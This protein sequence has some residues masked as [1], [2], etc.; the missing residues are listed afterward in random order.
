MKKDFKN[1]K[2]TSVLP[3]ASTEAK[4][5]TLPMMSVGLDVTLRWATFYFNSNKIMQIIEEL[6]LFYDFETVTSNKLKKVNY[7]MHINRGSTN[8]NKSNSYLLKNARILDIYIKYI[9]VSGVF[10]IIAPA[11]ASVALYIKNEDWIFYYPTELWINSANYYIPIYI[12]QAFAI[13]NFMFLI[14]AAE[15]TLLMIMAHI[16][17]QFMQIAEELEGIK[18]YNKKIK[19]LIN[20]HCRISE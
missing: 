9:C 7:K 6:K 8:V 1:K 4:L 13:L 14:V 19:V 16:I 2:F 11:L 5:K 18:Q 12:L 10:Y 15:A 17:Y 20:K 3:G